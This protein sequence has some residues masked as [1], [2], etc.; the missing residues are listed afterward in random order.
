MC[1]IPILYRIEI[2]PYIVSYPWYSLGLNISSFF[3]FYIWT[4]VYTH[5]R[6][7]RKFDTLITFIFP[8]YLPSFCPISQMDSIKGFMKYAIYD[9]ITKASWKFTKLK[10]SKKKDD[11]LNCVKNVV[12]SI[13]LPVCAHTMQ[14][15]T[16]NTVM[17]V[18]QRP[19]KIWVVFIIIISNWFES[20]YSYGYII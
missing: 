18:R 15:P 4:C 17:V 11:Y 16:N 10:W 9:Q 6:L 3:G 14:I 20:I 1:A 2:M 5:M 12:V 7:S 13:W 19:V 8:Y